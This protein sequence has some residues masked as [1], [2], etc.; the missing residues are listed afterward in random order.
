MSLQI[1]ET[2]EVIE[3]M[4]KV[5]AERITARIADK[6]DG[7]AD[8]LEQVLDL[9]GQALTRQ[10]WSALGYQSPTA[11]V[12]ERFSGA[13]KRLPIETR[14]SVVG[15]LSA[16]GMSTRA[17]APIVGVSQQQ[18][19]KDRREADRLTPEASVD[20][21]RKVMSLDGRQRPATQPPHPAPL[22]EWRGE[23]LHLAEETGEIVRITGPDSVASPG[24]A[25]HEQDPAK[26]HRPPLPDQF[27][28]A[29]YDMRQKVGRLVNLTEDD[30]FP[31]NAKKLALKHR[32]ELLEAIT[33]LQSV[34]TA[35]DSHAE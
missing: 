25:F 9:I 16:A 26:P 30:R 33:D 12:S 22:D 27:W 35:L 29:S 19:A 4:S 6:L 10:A 8:N 31:H 17:I 13:L 32:N 34:I 24:K 3:P 5:E 7:I 11:Y 23:V 1:I 18:V 28:K 14:R 20:P 21:D 15:E 2:G